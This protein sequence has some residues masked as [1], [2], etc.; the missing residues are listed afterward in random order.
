M[1]TITI[2]GGTGF[3]GLRLVQRLATKGVTVRVAV[4]HPDPAN[5]DL[6]A[7]GL[8]Q[9]TVFGADVRDQAAVAAAVRWSRRCR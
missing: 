9:I 3:L 2:F 6:R 8:D 4:R 7:T 5:R 1:A